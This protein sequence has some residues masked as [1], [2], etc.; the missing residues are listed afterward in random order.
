M[1]QV[2]IT[3]YSEPSFYAVQNVSFAGYHW[4]KRISFTAAC[5]A[6]TRNPVQH[7]SSTIEAI[8]LLH[9]SQAASIRACAPRDDDFSLDKGLPG[10]PEE[11]KQFLPSTN[12]EAETEMVIGMAMA[13]VTEKAEEA[14]VEEKASQNIAEL[15]Q[16][17]IQ[18]KACC[19]ENEVA[20]V[21]PLSCEEIDAESSGGRSSRKLGPDAIASRVRNRSERRRKGGLFARTIQNDLPDLLSVPGIGPRNFEKLVAKGIGKVAELK[22]LYRDKFLNNES[23]K[24]VE[25]LQT[26]VGIVHKKNAESITSYVKD[27][28]DEELKEQSDS[29]KESSIRQKKKVTI[30]VEGNISVGKT[31]FLQ[32]IANEIIE[33]RDLVEIV[34][35]PVDKWKDV[36]PDHF[37]LLDAFYNEPERYAYTFQNYV[38]ATRLMK[39]Q[40]TSKGMKPLR[41]MERS[42]FSDRLVFVRAVHEAKWMS[43]LE[44]RIYESWFDPFISALPG[45]VPDGFIY[46]RASPDTCL[47]RLHMRNRPEERSVTLE[48]LRGL[49]EKHEQCFFPSESSVGIY[50][51]SGWP[52]GPHRV[53]PPP[54][55]RDRVFYLE[56]DH[57]H[58]SIRK[59]PALILD[60]E[61]SIDF[62]R[63]LEARAEYAHQVAEFYEYIRSSKDLYMNETAPT[64]ETVNPFLLSHTGGLFRPDG[65]PLLHGHSLDAFN[66]AR[67]SSAFMR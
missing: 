27:C 30:C 46:L 50:S 33:L 65:R 2:T 15:P 22:Q 67:D 39:E 59:V 34:P 35:E 7:L 23:K 54:R 52:S 48:Y 18:A 38:F 49:H 44:L 17:D 63:D 16:K 55:I 14:R 4:Q 11:P 53:P 42:I 1:H 37:N 26:S 45:L 56:G 32:K 24:M 40:E 25:Y 61:A 31:T 19:E 43:E 28:V 57:L 10:V 62:T 3:A 5:A 29:D 41:L 64:S 8:S 6:Y 60:C 20:V 58:S 13:G 47:Q 21:P 12:C 66:F 51:V 36:G 9:R